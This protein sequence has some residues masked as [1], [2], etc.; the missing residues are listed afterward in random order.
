MVL[1]L[2]QFDPLDLLMQARRD[3]ESTRNLGYGVTAINDLANGFIFE[4]WGVSFV[5]H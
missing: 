2:I 4:F 1:Y 3:N 5:A